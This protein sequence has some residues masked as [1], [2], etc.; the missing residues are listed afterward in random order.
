MGKEGVG[1]SGARRGRGHGPGGCAGWTLSEG[2]P[3]TL[4]SVAPSAPVGRGQ[5]AGVRHV[6]PK[7][8]TEWVLLTAVRLWGGW[9]SRV[10]PSGAGL[11]RAPFRL[12]RSTG[13][14]STWGS[15]AWPS[16]SRPLDHPCPHPQP[17]LFTC[18][19]VPAATPS[20]HLLVSQWSPPPCAPVP[21]GC[22]RPPAAH[23][24]CSSRTEV[25]FL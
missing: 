21:T 3:G 20:P 6:G 23:H 18:Y 14:L 12:V 24:A 1:E 7:R 2:I 4:G 25:G 8:P 11:W 15:G 19:Y 5:H 22:P 13:S 16:C 17:P 10:C 9:D